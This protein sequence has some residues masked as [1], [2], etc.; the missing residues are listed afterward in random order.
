MRGFIQITGRYNYN[1]YSKHCGVDLCA[2]PEI[3]KDG[4]IAAL[5]LATYFK[6]RGVADVAE[7]EDWR[8]VRR[9]ING[10]SNGLAHFLESVEKFKKITAK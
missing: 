6:E 1:Y 4:A 3:A 2:N 9:L 8:K 7:K 5:I 10:G